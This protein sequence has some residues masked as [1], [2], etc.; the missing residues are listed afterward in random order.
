MI[1]LSS[2]TYVCIEDPIVTEK[3]NEAKKNKDGQYVYNVGQLD[4]RTYDNYKKPFPL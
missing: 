3:N 1:I 2:F 4:Y